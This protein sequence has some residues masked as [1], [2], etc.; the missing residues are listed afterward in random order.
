MDILC[1]CVFKSRV[2]TINS[3]VNYLETFLGDDIDPE[4][5]YYLTCVQLALSFIRD[6]DW[7]KV[8]L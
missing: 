2:K 6:L 1:F 3:I 8:W 5:M 4:K 7:N